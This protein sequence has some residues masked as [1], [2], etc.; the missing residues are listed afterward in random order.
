MLTGPFKNP[1]VLLTII[2]TIGMGLGFAL[3]NYVYLVKALNEILGFSERTCSFLI[4]LIIFGLLVV[5][6]EPEKIK[7]LA[8]LLSFFIFGSGIYFFHSI[9]MGYFSFF[10]NAIQLYELLVLF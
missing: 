5:I 8:F 10:I 4:Y 7:P 2:A 9:L 1:I 3:G 6:V